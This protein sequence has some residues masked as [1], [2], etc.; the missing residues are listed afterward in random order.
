[1]PQISAARAQAQNLAGMIP[2]QDEFANQ[3]FMLQGQQAAGQETSAL[4]RLLQQLQQTQDFERNS[5]LQAVLN[6]LLGSVFG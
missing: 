1:M 5:A 4:A 3:N 6:P 2:L